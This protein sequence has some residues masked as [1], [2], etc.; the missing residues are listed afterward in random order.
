M[1]HRVVGVAG[2]A[3]QQERRDR[4]V[5]L[6]TPPQTGF[7]GPCLAGMERDAA[8]TLRHGFTAPSLDSLHGWNRSHCIGDVLAGSR[9]VLEPDDPCEMRCVV[10]VSK[11][12]LIELVGRWSGIEQGHGYRVTFLIVTFALRFGTA[13]FVLAPAFVV[14]EACTFAFTF[15]FAFVLAGGAAA[16]RLPLG[17]PIGP[18]GSWSV[19]RCSAV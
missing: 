12:A 9:A 4:S 16:R 18:K 17:C 2:G 15:T 11:K 1:I 10:R 13:V 19:Y 8:L 7:G 6:H 5:L 14:G 3:W